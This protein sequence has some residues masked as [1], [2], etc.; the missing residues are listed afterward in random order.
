M[1]FDIDMIKKVYANMTERVDSAR[2]I[3]G[4]PLTLSEK[5]RRSVKRTVQ[6]IQSFK[7]GILRHST[8][9]KEWLSSIFQA[10]DSGSTTAK[11]AEARITCAPDSVISVE[12]GSKAIRLLTTILDVLGCMQISRIL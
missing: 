11:N 7:N 3:V 5:I 2:T 10:S 12:P 8:P 1:A 9:P 4:K 6:K